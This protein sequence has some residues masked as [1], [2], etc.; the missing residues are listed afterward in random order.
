MLVQYP[1]RFSLSGLMEISYNDYLYKIPALKKNNEYHVS[2]LQQTYG[3]RAGGFIYHPRLAVFTAGIKFRDNR[4]L[5]GV[6]GKVNSQVYGTDGAVTFLPYRPVTFVVFGGYTRDSLKP[7]G[8]FINSEWAVNQNLNDLYYG[9]RLT[10]LKRLWPL[11]RLEYEHR[12]SDFFN[13]GQ[14]YR[15]ITTNEVTFDIRGSFRFLNTVYLG[16]LR[17]VDFSS[18]AVSYK[19]KE[20]QLNLRSDIMT[21]VTFQN[22]FNYSD[23]DT[24]KL[25]S[26]GSNLE[27]RRNQ[28]FNQYYAYQFNRTEHHFAGIESQGIAGTDLKQTLNSLNG[29]W[30]YRFANGLVSS[31]ALN[32]GNEVDNNEKSN[33]YGINCSMSYGRPL[34]GLSFSPRYRFLFRKDDLRGELL[35]NNLELNLVSKNVSWGTIYSNYSLTVSNEKVRFRSATTDEFGDQPVMTGETKIDSIINLLRTG[36]RGR[37][38]GKRLSRAVWNIEAEVF[39]SDATI[40]RTGPKST[41]DEDG[42]ETVQIQTETIKRNIRR[43]SIRGNLAYP[44]GWASIF[45]STGYSLG[46]SNGRSLRRFFYEERIQYPIFRNLT[47]LIRWKQLWENIQDT[48]SRRVDEYNLTGEY[49]IGR[50]TVSLEGSVLRSTTD[51]VNIYVRRFFLKLRR[52]I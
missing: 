35:E 42:N 44:T 19:S 1:K 45:F 48:P 34:L 14:G 2:F 31:L 3:I 23:I 33:F 50:T 24:S 39:F 51:P 27:I 10:M 46:E 43:Y 52:I 40:K 32:Y 29:S 47:V 20:M 8:H 11:I 16:F 4:Q 25:F 22:A 38:P 49:R 41:F 12:S 13:P 30:T 17:Y 6:G 15:T 18:P 28:N 7:V 37:A 21:G 5:N 36:V 26:V 9:A